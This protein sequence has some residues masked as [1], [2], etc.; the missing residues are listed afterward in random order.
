[1]LQPEI[2]SALDPSPAWLAGLANS[3]PRVRGA[4]IAAARRAGA[5]SFAH[6]V[7]R[8]EGEPTPRQMLGILRVRHDGAADTAWTRDELKVCLTLAVESSDPLERLE[9]IRLIQLALGDVQTDPAP[10]DLLIG[11]VANSPDR[12]EAEQRRKI[13]ERL[14]A[15]F[16]T[17]HGALDG[18]IAR[19][20]AMLNEPVPGLLERTITFWQPESSVPDDLHLLMVSARIPGPRSQQVT[21]AIAEALLRL[22]AKLK[23]AGQF[24]SRSWPERVGTTLEHLVSYDAELPEILIEH[25]EFGRPAHAL[26]LARLPEP[27]RLGGA[28]RLLEVALTTDE[29]ESAWTPELVEALRVLPDEELLPALRSRWEDFRLRDSIALVLT[30][31]PYEA[32]RGRLIEALASSQPDVTRR[33]ARA[34]LTLQPT[35]QGDDLMTAL[36]ALRS[37]CPAGEP[38]NGDASL[39]AGVTSRLVAPYRTH[40]RALVDLLTHWTGHR[41]EQ[42]QSAEAELLTAHADWVGGPADTRPEARP[43]GTIGQGDEGVAGRWSQVDWEQE[44]SSWSVGVRTSDVIV[45]IRATVAWGPIWSGGQPYGHDDVHGHSHP[46][47]DV[48]TLSDDLIATHDG[49]IYHGVLVYESPDGTLIQTGPDNQCDYGRELAVQQASRQSL[50]PTGLLHGATDQELADLYVF[51]RSLQAE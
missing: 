8:L 34:L 40:R 13:A 23:Q 10:P 36:E 42:Q 41:F 6:A 51:L 37:F 22:D 2:D 20:L 50:M 35:N 16:P 49:L 39:A 47:R 27:S 18:E 21:T 43:L 15:A 9:A 29:E 25:K 14:V 7:S 5:D 1:M 26:M 24:P 19:L 11:Y 30:E 17:G 46:S 44:R 3:S 12:I 33:A 28:R 31:R 45:V 4:V 38:T 48:A 32:D